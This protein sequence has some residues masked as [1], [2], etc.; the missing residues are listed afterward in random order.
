M[1]RILVLGII[2]IVLLA[3]VGAVSAAIV[4]NGGFEAPTISDPY[5]T[6][7][8]NNPAPG[9]FGWSVG[10]AGVDQIGS[11]WPAAEGAQSLDLSALGSGSITQTLT[12]TPGTKYQVTF[13]MAGNA[14]CGPA[15]KTVDVNWDSQTKTATFDSTGKSYSNMGWVA[16]SFNFQAG[17]GSTVLQF[18]DTTSSSPCGVAL[19]NIIVT[20]QPIPTPEFPTMALPAA[21]IIGLLGVVLFMQRT[22]E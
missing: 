8:V 7:D 6:Y 5:V 16:K 10:G 9:S 21:L 13:D 14:G 1:K 15:I 19:D 20:E 12:T 4:T 18:V 22:K 11:Y 2:S 17:S 3:C